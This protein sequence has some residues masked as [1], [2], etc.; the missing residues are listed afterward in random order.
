MEKR[1][2]PKVHQMCAP[3]NSREKKRGVTNSD[4]YE[5]KKA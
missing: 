1:E 2:I 3:L 4:S 5:K